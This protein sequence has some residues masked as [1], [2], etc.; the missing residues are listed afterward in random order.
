LGLAEDSLMWK[1]GKGRNIFGNTGAKLTS[2]FSCITLTKNKV[3]KI[4][5][6]YT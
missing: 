2:I 6:L 3:D 4:S 1:G 5:Y